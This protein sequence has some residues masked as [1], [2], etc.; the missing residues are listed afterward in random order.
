VRERSAGWVPSGNSPLFASGVRRRGGMQRSL[1]FLAKAAGGDASPS[2][3]CFHA[4]GIA[5]RSARGCTR[6]QTERP[7]TRALSEGFHSRAWRSPVSANPSLRYKAAAGAEASQSVTAS[8]K[9]S[10]PDSRA[11]SATASTSA[12]PRP[13]PL[14]RGSTHIP[15]S[16]AL[17]RASSIKK[18]PAIPTLRAS[19]TTTNT[20]PSWPSSLS[21][22]RSSQNS[23]ARSASRSSE[24]E[25]AYGASANARSRTPRR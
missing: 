10:A 20:T 14:A 3:C 18:P 11:Q 12:R 9:R 16:I 25:K 2:Q 7:S 19:S 6:A 22:T 21:V 8:R 4:K 24:D 23:G 5:R 17:A 15:Q 1:P 13:A